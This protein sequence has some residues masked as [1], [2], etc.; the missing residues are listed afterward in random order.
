M[1]ESSWSIMDLRA[2]D[3]RDCSREKMFV[4]SQPDMPCLANCCPIMP[5]DG[6]E[7]EQIASYIVSFRTQALPLKPRSG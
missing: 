6:G 2:R 3:S 4:A 7:D 5:R 1:M